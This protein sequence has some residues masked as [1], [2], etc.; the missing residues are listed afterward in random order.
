MK[1]K[2]ARLSSHRAVRQA[3]LDHAL[4]EVS[5][6]V[7]VSHGVMAMGDLCGIVVARPKWTYGREIGQSVNLL[8]EKAKPGRSARSQ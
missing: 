3:R 1:G 8:Q 5:K 6:I 7:V 4:H 2:S